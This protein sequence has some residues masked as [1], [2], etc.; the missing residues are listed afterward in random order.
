MKLSIEQLKKIYRGAYSFSETNDEYI[1]SFHFTKQQM[2][3]LE[4]SNDFWRDRNKASN[5][6]TLEF[7]TKATQ[8]SFEYKIAWIGSEDTIE[9]F[10]DGILVITH[11]IQ[12]LQREGKLSFEMPVQDKDVIIYLPTDAIIYIRDFETNAEIFPML[13]NDKVLWMG[14]S[15]T[16]GYGSFRSA[17]TYVS[18]ANRL[19]NYD[20]INQGIG[21]YVYDKNVL[22]SMEGYSPDKLIISFGTNQYDSESMKDVEEYYERIMRIYGDIPILCIT[23]IWRGDSLKRIH[24][25]MKFKQNINNICSK[26][27]N[28]TVVDGFKLVPHSSDY[29]MDDVHPN[30]IGMEIYGKNLV[31]AIQEAGF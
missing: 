30:A 2:Q 23:P 13:K 27:S 14:D 17:Y 7:R 25:L 29:F 6:K 11:H 3:Y 4:E 12:N 26:Y 22:Q 10:I 31:L 9:L 15:I 16:Q 21:G 1:Q 20:I 28:I 24:V 8:V 19:L 18:V 5:S